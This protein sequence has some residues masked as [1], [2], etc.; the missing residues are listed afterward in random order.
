MPVHTNILVGVVSEADAS[1]LHFVI[2]YYPLTFQC[3]LTEIKQ[4]IK[5]YGH[6]LYEQETP[7]LP[8]P[9]PHLL[10]LLPTSLPRDYFEMNPKC[11]ILL[12]FSIHFQKVMVL[13]KQYTSNTINALKS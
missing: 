2:S 12:Y 6:I 13:L 4:H 8:S 5:K 1:L 11:G 9:T 3:I 10:A 7:P